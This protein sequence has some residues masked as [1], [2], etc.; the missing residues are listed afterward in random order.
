MVSYNLGSFVADI[1]NFIGPS[2]V[3]SNLSGTNMNNLITQEIN[4]VNSLTNAGLGTTGIVEKYQP[5][6]TDLCISKIL[7]SIEATQGG[8]DSLSLGEL[9]V[10]QGSSSN[11]EIAIQLRQDAILRLKELGRFVRYA[12]IIG[13]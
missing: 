3:P 2:N 10:N 8:I 5:S 1:N 13:G 9:S 12:R 7:L 6:I 4:F 11:K